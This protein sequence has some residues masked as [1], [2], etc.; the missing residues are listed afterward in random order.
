MAED[1]LDQMNQAA[2]GVV[3]NI[4]ATDT[5]TATKQ[6]GAEKFD[7]DEEKVLL[8]NE[9]KFARLE[10]EDWKNRTARIAADL[11]N[12]TKQH[13]LDIQH[14][15]KS[16]KK[17][18]LTTIVTFINTLNLAFSFAPKTEDDSVNK[19]ILTLDLFLTKKSLN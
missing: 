9:L 19:F 8:E 7:L 15:K 14:A 2:E 11:Q 13:D 3:D 18:A 1:N 10:I 4:S 16:A 17:S 6:D 12:I 5:A